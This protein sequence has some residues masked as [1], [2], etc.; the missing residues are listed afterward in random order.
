ML[1]FFKKL[2]YV[3]EIESQHNWEESIYIIA[4]LHANAFRFDNNNVIIYYGGVRSTG[5]HDF[6]T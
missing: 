3:T 2:L 6:K 5:Y 4:T 1:R